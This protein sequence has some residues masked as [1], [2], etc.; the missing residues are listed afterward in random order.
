MARLKRQFSSV[1]LSGLVV[2]EIE[3]VSQLTLTE[4]KLLGAIGGKNI[5]FP[6]APA[7]RA[8]GGFTDAW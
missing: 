2:G 7:F 6:R 8:N 1:L 3:E 4:H 5:V